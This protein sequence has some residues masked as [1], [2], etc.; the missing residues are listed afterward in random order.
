MEKEVKMRTEFD[1]YRCDECG[2]HFP[3]TRSLG[4]RYYKR[5]PECPVCCC[6]DMI[7]HIYKQVPVKD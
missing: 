1:E 3:E 4:Q 5:D 7:N 6:D 2:A